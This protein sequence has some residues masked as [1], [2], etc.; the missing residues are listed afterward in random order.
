M[1]RDS[2]IP[3]R[4]RCRLA[5]AGALSIADCLE[6]CVSQP[7]RPAEE[8]PAAGARRAARHPPE[9]FAMKCQQN[10]ASAAHSISQRLAGLAW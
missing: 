6:G 2:A 5:L 10:A 8:V 1:R 7:R 4:A 9:W 3:D